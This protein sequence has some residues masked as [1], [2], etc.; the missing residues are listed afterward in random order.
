MIDGEIVEN[1]KR[2]DNVRNCEDATLAVKEFDN[3]VKYK[4][5]GTLNLAYKQGLL[6]KKFKEAEMLKDIG[7]SR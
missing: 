6:F 7:I 5:K 3:I 4:K 2:S 1:K